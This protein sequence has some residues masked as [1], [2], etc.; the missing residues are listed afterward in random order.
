VTVVPLPTPNSYALAVVSD[1][2]SVVQALVNNIDLVVRGKH[3]E[4][5]WRSVVC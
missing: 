5:R 4:I 2:T 1:V 3:H